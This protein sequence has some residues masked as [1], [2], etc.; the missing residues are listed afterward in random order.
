MYIRIMCAITTYALTDAGIIR[1]RNETTHTQ[2][3]SPQN[4]IIESLRS[5]QLVNGYTA[6]HF[7]DLLF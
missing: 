2:I 1:T 4:I 6:T 5:G 3:E 7:M